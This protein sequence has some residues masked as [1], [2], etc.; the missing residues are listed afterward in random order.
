MARLGA[1][2]VEGYLHHDK[3]HRDSFIPSFLQV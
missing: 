2:D 3:E 1:G